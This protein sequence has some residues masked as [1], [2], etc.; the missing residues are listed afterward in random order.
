MPA[1]V[2][3]G[4]RTGF[5]QFILDR[6][7]QL[8]GGKKNYVITPEEY[9]KAAVE[10]FGKIEDKLPPGAKVV[11]QISPLEVVYELNG[12]QYR[13][14]RNTD[15]DLGID[16][17]RVETK[18][19]SSPIESQSSAG[20]M[21]LLKQILPNVFK[22]IEG[23]GADQS[24]LDK[25]MGN[26]D[27]LAGQRGFVALTPEDKALL[28]TITAAQDAKLNRQFA[29][30]QSS[31]IADLYGKGINRSNLAGQ[32]GQQL[33]E[34]QGL[35]RAQANADAA[36]RELSTLQFLTQALQGNRALAGD[37]YATGAQLTMGK[38]NNTLNFVS[39]LLNQAL[40]R[41]MGGVELQ[42]GQQ[43]IDNQAS[44]FDKEYGLAKTQ[45]ELQDLRARQAANAAKWKS[46]IGG[47]AGLGLNLATAGLGGGLAGLLGRGGGTPARVGTASQSGGYGQYY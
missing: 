45:T 44:Q 37:Q 40:Q 14:F 27:A 43:R 18:L 10:Y 39:N 22:N 33:V 1:N 32:A 11:Q 19:L 17:G 46:I 31:L 36:A 8:A 9:N 5:E 35:V 3:I 12:K 38:D 47:V 23:K 20:E 7:K 15:S 2:S 28:D 6:Q 34:G 16:T 13:A 4:A 41:E 24:W 21:D 26:A 30:Q 25:L 29:D 42:Q